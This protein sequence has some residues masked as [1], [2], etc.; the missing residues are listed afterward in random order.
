M[1]HRVYCNDNFDQ[2]MHH[3]WWHVL[4]ESRNLNLFF[5]HSALMLLTHSLS[6]QVST[7]H[8]GPHQVKH[9]F[10]LTPR[11]LGVR[12]RVAEQLAGVTCHDHAWYV[13]P[14][15]IKHVKTETPASRIERVIVV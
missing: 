3:Y 14:L 13:M 5:H 11:G 6:H 2:Q 15:W 10:T 12:G 9:D 1:Y 8:K 4:W 7:S